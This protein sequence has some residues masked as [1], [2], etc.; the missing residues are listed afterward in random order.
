M[1]SDAISCQIYKTNKIIMKKIKNKQKKEQKTDKDIL[2]HTLISIFLSFSDYFLRK[3]SFKWN[4]WD[5]GF[6]WLLRDTD[7]LPSRIII[8]I[9]IFIGLVLKV[10]DYL[11]SST[12]IF[13][14]Y[15]SLFFFFY[16]MNHYITFSDIFLFG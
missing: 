6:A 8:P 11:L 12:V 3:D 5:T 4:S 9:Y 1:E 14:M 13:H 15:T 2:M 10:F 16:F 7:K